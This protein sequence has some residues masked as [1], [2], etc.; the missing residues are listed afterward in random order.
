MICVCVFQTTRGLKLNGKKKKTYFRRVR[1]A[2]LLHMRCC[3]RDAFIF[4]IRCRMYMC[5]IY[6]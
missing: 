5:Y 2:E 1:L 6:A 3:E 4:F